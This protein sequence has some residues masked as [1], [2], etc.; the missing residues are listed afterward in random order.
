MLCPQPQ[1]DFSPLRLQNRA[2]SFEIWI[3]F[4]CCLYLYSCLL[5]YLEGALQSTVSGNGATQFSMEPTGSSHIIRLQR[6]V[7]HNLDCLWESQSCS[8]VGVSYMVMLHPTATRRSQETASSEGPYRVYSELCLVSRILSYMMSVQGIQLTMLLQ[9]ENSQYYYPFPGN[10]QSNR[11][12]ELYCPLHA[13]P[14]ILLRHG[15]ARLLFLLENGP[16]I[17]GAGSRKATKQ[18]ICP[19]GHRSLGSF[20]HL[21]STFHGRV[22]HVYCLYR[23]RHQWGFWKSTVGLSL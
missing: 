4:I 16:E 23:K 13:Q 17:A 21:V 2:G 6:C 22:R 19:C 11:P 10:R 1:A 15:H 14:D 18:S 3:L 20:G 8:P 5:F 12:A 7:S 9:C